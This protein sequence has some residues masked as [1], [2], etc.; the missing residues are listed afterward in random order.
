MLSVPHF[1]Q[2]IRRIR[3]SSGR[4]FGCRVIGSLDAFVVFDS[5]CAASLRILL[6]LRYLMPRSF[7]MRVAF[8]KTSYCSRVT[9]APESR[10]RPSGY[11]PL[12]RAASRF[13]RASDTIQARSLANREKE[14]SHLCGLFESRSIGRIRSSSWLC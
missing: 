13:R 5:A 6:I 11:I 1:S 12:N 9:D 2:V 8:G 14:E 7:G 4:I 3:A 10:R